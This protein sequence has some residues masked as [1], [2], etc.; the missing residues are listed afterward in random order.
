M[1][2]CLRVFAI[3]L[4]LSLLFAGW[5]L[6]PCLAAPV[7]GFEGRPE[8]AFDAD[9][10]LGEWDI[11]PWAVM[12]TV[13]PP[14]RDVPAVEDPLPPAGL[15]WIGPRYGVGGDS[16]LG[17]E[18]KE[19]F[20]LYDLSALW[21]LPWGWRHPGASWQVE[22]RLISSA[23]ELAAAGSTSFMATLVPAVAVGS[24]NGIFSIDLGLGF[25]FFSHY[26]FG[27]QN[28]GGPV[29]IVGTTGIGFNPFQGLHAGYRFQHFSDAGTYGP[30]SLGVDM[31][32]IEVGYVF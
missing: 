29:Q 30:T 3:G 8:V 1:R 9:S 10:V 22:T 24:R 5:A 28:F 25:G 12:L 23:G 15:F 27:V 20:R 2:L 13:P 19:D 18:Q 16:P 26:K 14:G 21:R 6:T 32:L 17:E 4:P 11:A 7:A 31:H